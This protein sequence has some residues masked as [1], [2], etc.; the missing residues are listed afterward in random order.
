MEKLGLIAEN[1]L[2]YLENII[3]QVC[4]LL[5][6]DIRNCKLQKVKLQLAKYS[7]ITFIYFF[8]L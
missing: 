6:E 2:D 7:Y 8:R 1:K 3:Q 4:P 5:A